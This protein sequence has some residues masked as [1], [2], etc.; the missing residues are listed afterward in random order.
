GSFLLT[1]RG[2]ALRAGREWTRTAVLPGGPGVPDIDAVRV[3]VALPTP[4][5]VVGKYEMGWASRGSVGRRRYRI[6]RNGFE[7]PLRVSLADRQARHLQGATGPT[8]N[9]PAGVS[10]F[11][12][13][14]TL[15]PWMEIG[16]TC[17]VCVMAV[18]GRRAARGRR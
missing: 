2:K 5:K 9:V 1:V 13:P 8:V 11:E 10:E 16:R 7:G 6:E 3:A 12:Y 15:P 14:V 18:G 17:R 4:F